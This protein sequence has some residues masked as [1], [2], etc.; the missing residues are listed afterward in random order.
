VDTKRETTIH[1]LFAAGDVAGGCPQKYVTGA[2]A[3]GEIAA[4]A[5]LP[6]MSSEICPPN[7]DKTEAVKQRL[8]KYLS[9]A[10]NPSDTLEEA[11]QAIMDE[12][13][14]GI[15][16]YYSFTEKSLKIADEKILELSEQSEQLSASNMQEL[17][18]IMELQERLVLCRSMIAHLAARK[19]T[20]WPGFAEY[21]GY[22]QKSSNWECY[23]NSQLKDGN[24]NIIHRPLV[25]NGDV[26]E[27]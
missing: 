3:E 7:A 14:G 27:H 19:E 25:Q 21:V 24:I 9:R 26:Y 1:G 2:L 16:T 10:E 20:R 13:A 15:G 22:P 18:Y 6:Y 4:K 12:H 23:V 5:A 11:M 17:V 8:E